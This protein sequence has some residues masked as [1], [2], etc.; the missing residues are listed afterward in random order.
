MIVRRCLRALGILAL[1][2]AIHTPAA[3]A[4]GKPI[5]I[6]E[7]VHSIGYLPLYVAMDKGYFTG[8]DVSTITLPSSGSAHTDAVLSGKAWGFIGGPEHNAYADVKGAQLKAIVNVVNRGNVYLFA[9]KGLT[10]GKD[11]KTFLK[12]KRI[13]VSAYGGTPNSITRYLL[14]KEG[15]DPQKDVTLLEV[16]TPAVPAVMAQG[17]ADIGVLD[18]PGVTKGIEGGVWQEPFYSAPRQFG[19]YA[20]ST[21]NVTQ[22]TIDND[23]ATVRTFVNGM[24][25]GL[26]LVRDH[27]D[28][29]QAIAA[30][31]FPD[32]TP[33]EIKAALDRAYSDQI[34]EFSGKITPESVKTAESVVEAAG[35]LTG[36]VPYAEIVDPEF[37]N[38]KGKK[39]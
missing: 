10:V 33:A 34:W 19:P 6:A 28:E 14:K 4:A 27:H 15:L 23:T 29:A 13:V 38:P 1:A 36:D 22:A 9:V 16:A 2:L 30:K 26:A 7:P 39:P 35:L 37:F 8:L 20:Y 12:G 11:L 24:L 5:L 31:E 25:R 17:R 21:V 3:H 18:E 32:L